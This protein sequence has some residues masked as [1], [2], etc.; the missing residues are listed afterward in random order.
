MG[1]KFVIGDICGDLTLLKLLMEKIAPMD[2]DYF[3]FTGSYM[4]PGPDSKGV[5]DY[6]I[7][8]KDKY[9][10]NFLLGCYEA[11]F[12]EVIGV[13]ESG[14]P[15]NAMLST[16]WKQMGGAKVLQ[17][18]AKDTD[19]SITMGN[20]HIERISMPFV[21]PEPHIRF[22]QKSLHIWYMD[23]DS[24][25]VVFHAGPDTSRF[26]NP[27][28][29]VVVMGENGWWESDWHLPEMT[30]VFSHIPFLKPFRKKGKVGIDLGAGRG[31]DK[32]CAYEMLSDE[33]VVVSGR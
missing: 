7:D 13:S 20:G 18:Y 14:K 29:E 8:F 22:L 27:R 3:L 21:I 33:T 4:G 2:T 11:L 30:I 9:K 5:L 26:Q 25:V 23:H 6:L 10:A 12:Q 19:I 17:S 32:L 28:T 16:L 15:A 24:P 1:R 31:G